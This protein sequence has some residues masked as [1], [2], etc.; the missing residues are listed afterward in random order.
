M[1]TVPDTQLPHTAK[2]LLPILMSILRNKPFVFTTIAVTAEGLGVA[3]A[4]IFFPKFLESQY[5][6]AAGVASF[7]AGLVV[8]PAGCLGMLLG[9]YLIRQF[10]WTLSSCIKACTAISFLALFPTL[11]LLLHCPNK[12]IAGVTRPYMNR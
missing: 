1:D 5:H 9:G 6:L 10:Q 4:T 2:Q 8:I 3:G 7:Y 11:I 12:A